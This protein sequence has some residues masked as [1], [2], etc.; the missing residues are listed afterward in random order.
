M[1][2]TARTGRR[3]AAGIALACAAIVLPAVALASPAVTRTPARPGAAAANCRASSTE[4]WLG[5]P[6]DGTA[7]AIYYELE[8]S[9]VGHHVCTL[10]GYPG[11]SAIRVNGHQV[12][13]PASHSGSRPTV[14]LAPGATAHA[15]LRVTDAGAVC[16]HP[17]NIVLLKVY[18]PGQTRAQLI[19]VSGLEIQACSHRRTMHVLPVRANTGIPGYTIS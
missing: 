5:L 6:G 14:T 8:F 13:A 12:G 7:G 17:V 19:G 18:P 2:L 1:N 11:V 15:V 3:L 9:N 4:V 16:A 10:F